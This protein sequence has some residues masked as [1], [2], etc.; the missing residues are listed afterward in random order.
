[1]RGETV[2]FG[3]HI[4]FV[5]ESGDHSL[6]SVDD[7]YPIFCLAFCI[8]EKNSYAYEVVPLFEELKFRWFGHDCFVLHESDIVRKRKQFSFLQY[9]NKRE[10][11]MKELSSL[12]DRIP[13]T[14]IVSVIEKNRLIN[15]Y[16]SPDNPYE[17]SLLFCMERAH[18]FICSK[19]E[20]EKLCHIVCESRS[21]REKA[22]KGKED[23]DLEQEFRKIKNGE[24][25][26]QRSGIQMPCFDIHFVSKQA[27]SIGLQIA[28]LVARP[29]GLQVLR[30]DQPNRA[31]DV[32]SS[33]IWNFPAGIKIFPEK[34]K[35]SGKPK[36]NADQE[37]T[38]IHL[39]LNI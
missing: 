8:F 24:H 34:A 39:P 15:K 32:I 2:E 37:R 14:V 31:Y 13:M 27:N 16:K 9:D 4:I 20:S 29:I 6:K 7:R 26:L 33:K 38:P 25:Y 30:P 22:G 5:D 18:D 1:M 19:R 36:P 28:D 12:L 11:F 23:A 17:L 21:P 10:C 35:D 3:D